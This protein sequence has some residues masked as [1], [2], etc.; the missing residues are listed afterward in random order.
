MN[1]SE[2]LEAPVIQEAFEEL[3]KAGK[4][5]FLGVS[6][7]SNEVT[8]IDTAVKLGYYDVVLTVYNFMSPKELTKSIESANKANVGIVIMKSLM[9]LSEL[10]KFATDKAEIYKASLKWVLANPNVTNII[11]TMRTVEEV[12]QDVSIVGTKVSYN[13]MRNLGEYA[14]ALDKEYCRLCGNCSGAC[15]QGVATNDIIR[16][17]VYYAGYGDRDRAIELYRELDTKQT[18]AN[19]NGC[20][21]CS[22]ACPYGLDVVGKITRVHALLA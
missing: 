12:N 11:P 13:N 16:Y 10:A 4:V 14:Q 19:C 5:R 21:A 20:G 2:Q 22:S 6:T 18:V 17:G 15:P 1:R 7:H 3:K 9:P 8:I